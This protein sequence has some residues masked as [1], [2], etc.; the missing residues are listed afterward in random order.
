M[1][2]RQEVRQRQLERAEKAGQRWTQ[3]LPRRAE[4]V[5][6]LS[7]GGPELAD[8]HERV[9]LYKAREEAKQLAYARAGVTSSFLVSAGLAPPSI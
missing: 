4:T 6:L 5:R 1:T 9:Q 7:L 3:L 8:S 2:H